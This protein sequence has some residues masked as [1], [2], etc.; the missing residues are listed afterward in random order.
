LAE[1]KEKVDR[2]EEALIELAK[3]QRR[4]EDKLQ[5]FKDWSQKNIEEIRKEIE[6]FK[7]WTKQNIEG[8]K[9]ETEEFREW[10]KQ[11]LE[12]IQ[13]SSDEFKE[14]TKQNIRELNKKW[15]EL[16][17]K[18][19]TIAEDI[20]APALPDIVKKYFGCI[21]IHDISVRRTKRKPNDP[22]KVREFDVII[23]CDDKVILNQTKATPRSEYAREFAQFVKSGEFFEYF[24]EYKGKE[25]IPIFSSLNLPVNIVKYLTKRKIY[26]MAMRG[27]YMDILNFNEV[28]ERKNQ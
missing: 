28:A 14:W 12:R 1:I 27:E 7:E 5:D 15:G 10:A 19:G 9:K 23:L 3:A 22:S 8:M 13:R 6:E 24:P 2:L 11:N 21:T 4:T 25:L 26:A 17:N 18:L 16:S 20:V